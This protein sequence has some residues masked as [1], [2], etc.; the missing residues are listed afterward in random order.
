[1]TT[2]SELHKQPL[3][4]IRSVAEQTGITPETLRAWERR[5]GVPNPYRNEHGYRFYSEEEIATLKWLKR[6]REGGMTI[7]Q[8]V[9]LIRHLRKSGQDPVGLLAER[10]FSGRGKALP[11]DALRTRLTDALTALDAH[12]AVDLLEQAFAQHSPDVVLL[13]G[14]APTLVAIGELWHSGELPIAV[15]HFASNLCHN[16]IVRKMKTAPVKGPRGRIVAACAPGEWHDLGLLMITVLLR[17]QRWE[18]TYL[19]ANLSLE[20]LHEVLIRLQP[21][22][23]LF[24]TTLIQTAKALVELNSVL[25]VL[26]EPRPLIGLGGQA[27]L[28]DPS[29]ANLIPGTLLGPRADDAVRQIEQLL[30]PLA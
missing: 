27:F 15:E 28:Q 4:N 20:R 18:V 26:P 3:F 19:G 14:V 8:A 11:V 17:N 29:L 23:L 22:L 2:K 9:E 25:R 12:Q 30:T 13:D 1:M 21:Q 16:F 24:S 7:R 6:Q 5:Y 10:P